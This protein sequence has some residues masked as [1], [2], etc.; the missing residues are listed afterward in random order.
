MPQAT[1]I[2]LNDGAATPVAVSYTPFRLSDGSIVYTD[3][4]ESVAAVRPTFKTKF[5]R[6]TSK[7]PTNRV[8]HDIAYPVKKTVDGVVVVHA[9]N[10]AQKTFIMSIDSD[11]QSN[12]HLRALSANS[13]D[14]PH[15]VAMIETG[16][17]LW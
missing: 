14:H 3:T 11:L 10:R 13:E 15:M 6:Y 16:E 5:D 8:T 7:R 12:K 17:G 1:T 4:R 2:S 9:V